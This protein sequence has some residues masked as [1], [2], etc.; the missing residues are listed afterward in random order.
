[1]VFRPDL[2]KEKGDY[3]GLW[4]L[5][6]TIR[7]VCRYSG[8]CIQDAGVSP[9]YANTHYIP[10]VW[11]N[12]EVYKAVYVTVANLPGTDSHPTIYYGS[13]DASTGVCTP[14]SGSPFTI[15]SLNANTQ[16]INRF[17]I[18]SKAGTILVDGITK[19]F[20]LGDLIYTDGTHWQQNK[21]DTFQLVPITSKMAID[22]YYTKSQ[23]GRA[24]PE[25]CAQEGINLH[26]YQ[27]PK[28]D[29]AYSISFSIVPNLLN[30]TTDPSATSVAMEEVPLPIEAESVVIAGAKAMLYEVPMQGQWQDP[31]LMRQFAGLAE[32]YSLEYKRLLSGLRAEALV[33]QSGSA[34]FSPANF[35]GRSYRQTSWRTQGWG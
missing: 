34:I 32:K 17:F 22:T 16:T 31:K 3:F 4:A 5:E 25:S 15:V 1:M 11:A 20:E 7:E 19:P 12:S 28:Y 24:T 29:I 6:E 21:R 23:S 33:G 2:Q 10:L 30:H 13:F 35:T 18:C 9:L 14:I 26:F 27:P 8:L